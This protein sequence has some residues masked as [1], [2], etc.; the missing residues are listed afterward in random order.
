MAPGVTDRVWS[1]ADIVSIIEGCEA[2]ASEAWP[3]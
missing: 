2:R 1:V 3:V